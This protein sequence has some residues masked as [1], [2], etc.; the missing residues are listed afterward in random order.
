M[1]RPRPLVL[2][3]VLALAPLSGCNIARIVDKSTLTTMAPQ[4]MANPDVGLSCA[5]GATTAPMLGALGKEGKRADKA[6]VLT[7]MSAAMCSEPLAWDAELRRLGA[8]RRGAGD[9]TADLLEVERRAH[10]EAASRYL[11]AW[12]HLETAFGPIGE[13]CPSLDNRKNED[14]LFLLGLSTGLLALVHD[15]GSG[16]LVGVSLDIPRKVERAAACLDDA[17]WWGV[18]GALQA[19]IWV[20]VP[21]ALPAGKDA[22]GALSQAAATGDAA[23]VRLARAFQIQSLATVGDE[24]GLKAA[25][26]EHAASQARPGSNPDFALLNAYAGQLVRHESDKLWLKAAGQR[27]PSA[28]YGTF[29]QAPANAGADGLDD[30]LNQ[31]LDAQNPAPAPEGA[32][33]TTP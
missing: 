24:A 1:S 30:L 11:A 20:T 4:I 9:E 18:P 10:L 8:A 23:G 27:T 15:Q 32:P 33:E 19:A 2:T 16:G 12:E 3:L 21:G 6:L 13:G 14:L 31:F 17:T 28:K 22:F 7:Y 25:V 5:L 26:A 29:P